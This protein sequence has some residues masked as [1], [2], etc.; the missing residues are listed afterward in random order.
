M[1]I[2]GLLQIVLFTIIPFVW[3]LFRIRKRESFFNW[4][5]V[6]P[7]IIKNKRKYIHITITTFIL[8]ILPL[9]ITILFMD[10]AIMATSQFLG[11]GSEVIVPAIIYS[12][13]QTG[14]SEEVFFRGFLAKR[15]I[16]R[17]GFSSGNVIQGLL[18][19]LLH[20]A[21]FISFTGW[22]MAF[23]IVVVTGLAGWLMGYINE[24][25]SGGSIISSWI[26][27]SFAN[28]VAFIAAM[29]KLF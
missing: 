5:G 8:M 20:G 21:I 26:L 19:G 12:F 10:T 3:W 13:L 27:H 29:Y 4:I 23:I 16:A 25:H 2:S 24:K 15:L 6:K 17:I 11:R 22:K 9:F 14:L 18:F 7:I 28:L 1:L